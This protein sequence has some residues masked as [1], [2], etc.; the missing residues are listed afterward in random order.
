MFLIHKWCNVTTYL[1]SSK[2]QISVT[3]NASRSRGARKAEHLQQNLSPEGR[4]PCRN[5][6]KPSRQRFTL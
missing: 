2:L 3:I 1:D 5:I 6:D 4:R